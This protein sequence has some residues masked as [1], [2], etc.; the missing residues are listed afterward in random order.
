MP[1]ISGL[2]HY[3]IV[4]ITLAAILLC[5]LVFVLAAPPDAGDTT[6]ITI[7]VKE[8]Q[9]LKSIA[10]LLKENGLIRS[11]T[12]FIAYTVLAGQQSHLKAGKYILSRSKNIPQVAY[13][14]SQ[15]LAESED[16]ELVVPE[17]LNLWE[18]DE[19]LTAKFNVP[20]GTFLTGNRYKEGRFF[21][22]T[23]RLPKDA[24]LADA[25]QRMIS[26]YSKRTA[27]YDETALRI[28]SILEKEAKTAED[29][30]LVSGII[31]KRM[32]MRI[33]LQLDATVA[34]GWCL[35][36]KGL[37][38]PCDVTQAPI[39]TELKEDGPYNTYTRTGLPAGPI[40]NPGL[41]AL[42]AAAHPKTS[43]YLYYLST[44]DGSQLIYAKT[45]AEHA[46]NRRKYLG[47]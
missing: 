33:P 28:A 35:R 17:G 39:A 18:L 45:P 44:R 19:L 25:V 15:G 41:K 4:A 10:G 2:K 36:V 40:S 23:Y 27:G 9:G 47:L 3:Q 7:T 5:A 30:S 8:G 34:Y 21:P 43:D 24:I 32:E 12:V 13:I 29:M 31:R 42:D 37:T 46:A 14:L 1:I 22:D 6:A 26:E 11:R 16:I 20:R 38:R